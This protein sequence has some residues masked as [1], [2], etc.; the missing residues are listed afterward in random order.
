MIEKSSIL[1]GLI[2]KYV[3]D[4]EQIKELTFTIIQVVINNKRIRTQKKGIENN[5]DMFRLFD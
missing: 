1:T 4:N 5:I 2:I 3:V